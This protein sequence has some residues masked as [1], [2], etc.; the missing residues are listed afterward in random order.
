MN[1]FLGIEMTNHQ[2]YIILLVLSI[3]CFVITACGG[4]LCILAEKKLRYDYAIYGIW[5]QVF[6]CFGVMVFSLLGGCFK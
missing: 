3:I 5:M 2:A 1:S 4:I 6:G